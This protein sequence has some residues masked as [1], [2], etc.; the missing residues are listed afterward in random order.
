M[1][2]VSSSLAMATTS[3][4]T[5][6]DK[7]RNVENDEQA[8]ATTAANATS[9]TSSSTVSTDCFVRENVHKEISKYV[10]RGKLQKLRH[11]VLKEVISTEYLDSLFPDLLKHFDPQTVHYNGGIAN[12][13]E[14]KISCYLEVMD[15]GVP[16]TNPNLKLLDLFNPLLSTCNDLFLFWY[17][18]QHS[19]NNPRSSAF[20]KLFNNKRSVLTS[21][22]DNSSANGGDGGTDNVS[23]T[24][25]GAATARQKVN[26]KTKLTC[27]R[28]MTFIT[29]YT[30]APNEQALL[31]VRVRILCLLPGV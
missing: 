19:C 25:T 20:S 4:V 1:A 14:W 11:L 24:K 15:G 30:P 31:K 26:I 8:K 21:K 2:S 22:N 28:V 7:G 9:K 13:K 10:L 16:C 5:T 27:R 29:R 6:E 12:I 23:T 3:S 17:R 18:Q